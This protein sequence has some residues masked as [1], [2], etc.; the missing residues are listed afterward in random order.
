MIHQNIVFFLIII[1]FLPLFYWQKT[2][3]KKEILV[4]LNT[5]LVINHIKITQI[6]YYLIVIVLYEALLLY[7]LGFEKIF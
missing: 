4:G 1:T 5:P 7:K 6:T 2:K 3:S